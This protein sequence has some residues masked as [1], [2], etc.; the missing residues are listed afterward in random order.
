MQGK[1]K[2]SRIFAL[3]LSITLFSFLLSKPAKWGY[4]HSNRLQTGTSMNI[5]IFHGGFTGTSPF[6]HR[7]SQF[8]HRQSQFFHRKSQFFHSIENHHFSIG[9]ISLDHRFVHGKLAGFFLD[10]EVTW[11]GYGGVSLGMDGW[12]YGTIKWCNQPKNGEPLFVLCNNLGVA[13]VFHGVVIP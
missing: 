8:F 2:D 3:I 12:M 7:Q 4:P 9:V 1:D 11:A 5:T 10:E 13:Q 6:F